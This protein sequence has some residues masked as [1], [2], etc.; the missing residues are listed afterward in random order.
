MIRPALAI[1]LAVGAA[2]AAAEPPRPDAAA[3]ESRYRVAQRLAAEGSPEAAHAFEQVLEA[4]PSGPLAD[5]ALVGLAYLQGAPEWPE[6]LARLDAAKAS[7]TQSYLAKVLD[8]H[9]GADRVPEARYL[10]ALSRLAPIAS[11]DPSRAKQD[12]LSEALAPD[13]GRWGDRARYALGWLAEQEGAASR[14]AGAYARLV[15]EGSEPGVAQRARVAFARALMRTGR[16]DEAAARLQAAVDDDGS[17]APAASALRDLAVK[18]ILR[19]RDPARRWS[20]VAA[21][22]ATI[23]TTRGATLLATASD[24][25]LI[26]YDKKNL[27]LQRF[28]TKGSGSG[29]VP[30]DEVTAIATDPYGRSFAAA[31]DALLARDGS[32]WVS[33]AALGDFG[34]PSALAIDAAGTVWVADR[35]GDRIGKIPAGAR[36]P[37]IARESKGAGIVAL[38][39]AEGRL[40]VAE[41]RSGTLIEIPPA[42]AA[43]S[44]G[45][46]FRRPIALAADAAGRIAVLDGKAGTLTRLSVSGEVTDTLNLDA[47]GVAKPVAVAATGDGS[48]RV[49]DGASGAVAVAP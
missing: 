4:S 21:P 30:Q 24:G 23:P 2:R 44:F 11:R 47:A 39:A 18:E 33:V 12:L 7:A 38:V 45:P 19:S 36:A 20:A 16:F 34:R 10:L 17:A 3:A 49:L 29:P 15:V 1:A 42:G 37:T 35:R 9:A 43:H 48:V 25:S 26:V 13:A 32:R 22:L 46:A 41:E 28:D 8:E 5:D 6:D 40:I 31:G 14:A 27:A